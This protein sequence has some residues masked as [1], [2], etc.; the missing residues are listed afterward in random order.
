MQTPQKGETSLGIIGT[1]QGKTNTWD[2]K[3]ENYKD[4]LNIL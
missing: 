3:A 1:L 2:R 4:K